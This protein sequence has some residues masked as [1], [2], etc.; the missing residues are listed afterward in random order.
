MS[1]RGY[2][3]DPFFAAAPEDFRDEPVVGDGLS[4]ASNKAATSPKGAFALLGV[5][6]WI[7]LI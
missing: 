1:P 7:F 4:R 2:R 6:E 3:K 5:D